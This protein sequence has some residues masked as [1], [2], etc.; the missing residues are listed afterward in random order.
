MFSIIID[1]LFIIVDLNLTHVLLFTHGSKQ[2]SQAAGDNYAT[3]NQLNQTT[4]DNEE[5]NIEANKGK[6]G[7]EDEGVTVKREFYPVISV[8]LFVIRQG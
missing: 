5:D 8:N 2:P 4:K 1:P 6:N 3:A 7:N